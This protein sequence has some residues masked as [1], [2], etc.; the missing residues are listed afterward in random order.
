VQQEYR[1]PIP[2]DFQM[3][4]EEA[5]YCESFD[6]DLEQVYW[7]RTKIDTDFAGDKDWFNQEYPATAD[8]AFLKVG[9]QPLIQT[10][11]VQR[12][13]KVKEA[14]QSR[15]GAHV[16][17]VDPARF[18]DDSTVIIHRQGRVAW[19]KETMD[20]QDTMAVA[21]RCARMLQDDPT[22]R[23]MFIDI[24]GLGAGIYDRLV[25][26][27][28]SERITPVN[29][30]ERASDT[31]KYFNKRSEMWGEMAEWLHDPITPCIPDDDQ[32]HGDLTAPSFTWS[33][34]GQ[35]KLDPKEKIKKDIG[36]SPDDGDALA[37]TFA[38]PVAADDTFTEDWRKRLIAKRRRK[39][40][41]SA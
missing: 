38:E 13:R 5:D 19:G 34:N 23:M 6:L 36:R 7:M 29:F 21:G 22:I 10:L 37:L 41:M 20:Q 8:M 24:G 28:F 9:H 17:G 2:H 31:R 27:G 33:S 14:H 12:A 25:E 18:G 3:T 39:T 16:V 32:L 30:G 15:I 40:A 4:P 26:L 35:M 1:R 11:K